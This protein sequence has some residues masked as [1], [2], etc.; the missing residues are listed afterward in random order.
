MP[1]TKS[2][3]SPVPFA[4]VPPNELISLLLA[5]TA[6]ITASSW[7]T[8]RRMRL[9]SLKKPSMPLAPVAPALLNAE[10]AL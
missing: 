9:T 7:V 1:C 10:Y 8:L 2:A 5:V 3:N 6:P 4:T